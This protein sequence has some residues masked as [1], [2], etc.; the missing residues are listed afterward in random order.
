MAPLSSPSASNGGVAQDTTRGRPVVGQRGDASPSQATAIPRYLRPNTAVPSRN[1][2]QPYTP[3]TNPASGQY[4]NQRRWIP[5][6]SYQLGTII[7]ADLHEEDYLRGAT[8][9]QYGSA[10]S[11]TTNGEYLHS[12]QRPHIVVALFHD[13]YTAIPCYTHGGS[14]L[15]NK[16]NRDEY[17]SVCDVQGRFK[18]LSHHEPLQ[19]EDLRGNIGATTSAWFTHPVSR[20]YDLWVIHGG[21]LTDRSTQD[22]LNLYHGYM[23]KASGMKYSREF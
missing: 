12:K 5:K 2:T 17:V 8:F 20:G 15:D 10:I 22:L 4:G 13:H 16:L 18:P 23:A 3:R 6:G 1:G 7:W 21:R 19:T 11:K 9:G 14:G